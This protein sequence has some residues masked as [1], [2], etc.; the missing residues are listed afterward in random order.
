MEQHVTRSTSPLGSTH[1]TSGVNFNSHLCCN[2]CPRV[3]DVLDKG[4]PEKQ[5]GGQK[6]GSSFLLFWVKYG[7]LVDRHSYTLKPGSTSY[8]PEVFWVT[9]TNLF[10][11]PESICHPHQQAWSHSHWPWAW[12]LVDAAA[13]QHEL[14]PSTLVFFGEGWYYWIYWNFNLTHHPN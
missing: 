3:L 11:Y 5:Q 7:R 2:F 13:L 6:K 4:H 12:E 10:A 1:S 9:N 8:N 14:D